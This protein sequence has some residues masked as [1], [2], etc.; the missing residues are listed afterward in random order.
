MPRPRNSRPLLPASTSSPASGRRPSGRDAHGIRPRATAPRHVPSREESNAG[1]RPVAAASSRSPTGGRGH[2]ERPQ[3][4]RDRWT[5]TSTTPGS[6]TGTDRRA[7]RPTN[8]AN[9]KV[10]MPVCPP[11]STATIPP[12][13]FGPL[14]LWP[15][16]EK[17]VEPKVQSRKTVNG[18][19]DR[20]PA[21]LPVGGE[22]ETDRSRGPTRSSRRS[23][24]CGPGGP[25]PRT[26]P[27]VRPAVM[28]DVEKVLPLL[29][30]TVRHCVIVQLHSGARAGELVKLRV[31]DIDRTDPEAWVVPA[32]DPQGD[33]EGEGAD[34]LLRREVPGNAG[35][36]DAEGGF[37]GRLRLLPGPVG[38]RAQRSARR[39]ASRHSTRPMPRNERKRVEGRKRP[40]RDHYTTGTYRPA[41]RLRSGRRSDVHA[42]PAPPPRGDARPGRIGRRCRPRPAGPFAGASPRS[43]P[44]RWIGS[45]R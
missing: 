15:S 4:R 31:G 17:F 11:E 20:D 36:A 39:T 35:P 44:P 26:Y 7:S 1:A 37:A 30:P 14:A 12:S 38:S 45:L 6:T 32:G 8:S 9:S 19:V 21:N 43:T 3:P 27:P 23:R 33:V 29:S 10:V 34:D 42:P 13:E 2:R 28:A 16:A 25:K 18:R 5:P 40:P 24:G 22:R 41:M